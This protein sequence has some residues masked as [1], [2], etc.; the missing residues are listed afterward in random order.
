MEHWRLRMP[1]DPSH[2]NRPGQHDLASS[3][4]LK[5]ASTRSRKLVDA[6]RRVSTKQIPKRANGFGQK[7]R[8][9]SWPGVSVLPIKTFKPFVTC[10]HHHCAHASSPRPGFPIHTI[11]GLV[12]KAIWTRNSRCMAP[13]YTRFTKSRDSRQLNQSWPGR[14]VT[15]ESS[16]SLDWRNAWKT[17]SII[18]QKNT[19]ALGRWL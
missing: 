16:S 4:E 12:Y 8:D 6:A 1:R 18:S 15:S 10:R 2:R 7:L 17:A 9:D 14:S 13:M 5:A 19:P 3:E 11:S